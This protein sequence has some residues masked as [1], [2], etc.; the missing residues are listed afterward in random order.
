MVAQVTAGYFK[1]FDISVYMKIYVIFKKTAKNSVKMWSVM[2]W[3]VALKPVK[4][5]QIL[6]IH[7]Q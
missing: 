7:V 2:S 3:R 1:V 6:I 5:I 4:H